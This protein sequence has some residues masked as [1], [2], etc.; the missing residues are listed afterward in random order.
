MNLLKDR[1][2][3]QHHKEFQ[4]LDSAINTFFNEISF[5]N[6][7][8]NF[9]SNWQINKWIYPSETAIL[10]RN[11][12]LFDLEISIY[13]MFK[14]IVLNFLLMER[15]HTFYPLLI[16]HAQK[17]FFTIQYNKLPL[18]LND[19]SLCVLKPSLVVVQYINIYTMYLPWQLSST[20]LWSR[21]RS[22][23][24]LVLSLDNLFVLI[25]YSLPLV[26]AW[27]FVNWNLKWTN[28][29]WFSRDV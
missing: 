24:F 23:H 13:S 7:E 10:Y 17:R 18:A 4:F 15:K 22:C 19:C 9:K 12:F 11:R 6:R 25:M 14:K 29:M 8:L 16:Q 26:L 2:D 5:F 3:H 20:I 1:F 27:L 21:D 28:S